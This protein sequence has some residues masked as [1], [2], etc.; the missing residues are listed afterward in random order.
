[1]AK[2][3]HASAQGRRA[4]RPVVAAALLGLTGGPVLAD[5]PGPGCPAIRFGMGMGDCPGPACPAY[6]GT[7]TDQQEYVE[8]FGAL[9]SNSD[10][11][12]PLDGRL[13]LQVPPP[14]VF[15]TQMLNAYDFSRPERPEFAAACT[16]L[17]ALGVERLEV[18]GL[19]PGSSDDDDQQPARVFADWLAADCAEICTHSAC[20]EISYRTPVPSDALPDDADI[21]DGTLLIEL[22]VVP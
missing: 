21:P 22:R 10:T 11:P 14:E 7:L 13:L 6:A 1:M 2:K 12:R 9:Q 20:P 17:V 8:M 18:I 15:G 5:C 3:D 16:E 19:S 4:L